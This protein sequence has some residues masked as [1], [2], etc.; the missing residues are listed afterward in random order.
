MRSPLERPRREW[1]VSATAPAVWLTMTLALTAPA[2]AP[3]AA[4]IP[5]SVAPTEAPRGLQPTDAQVHTALARLNE[6]PNLG[7]RKK[8]RT[9]RWK[10]SAQEPEQRR[11]DWLAWIADA[12]RWLAATAR[13]VLWVVGI[14]TVGILGLYVKRFLE[15]RGERNRPL[16]IAMPT[17]VRDLD[18]RPESLPDDIGSSALAL[19]ERGEHRASLSLLYR[20]MLSRLAHA[21]AVP[22]RDSTTEGDCVQLAQSHLQPEP[23]AYVTRLIKVWQRAVYGSLDPPAEE[24]RSL[25]AG[26]TAEIGNPRSAAAT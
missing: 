20:G 4:A 24:I 12:F 2:G 8:S 21:H 11:G 23:A 17:H 14:L 22:I 25:C 26:F 5:T 16:R 18:I 7:G 13:A 1:S 10:S 9:L 6:D 15:I 19:W 3:E